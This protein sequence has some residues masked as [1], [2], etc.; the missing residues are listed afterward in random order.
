MNVYISLMADIFHAGHVRLINEGSKLGKLTV[1]LLSDKACSELGETP[2]LSYEKRK[3]VL[4]SIRGVEK[5]IKQN[6]ASYLKILPKVK[7]DYV[8]HGDDWKNNHQKIYRSEVV[9]YLKENGGELIEIP[10]SYDVNALKLK[11]QAIKNDVSSF[12]RN[13]LIKYLIKTKKTIRLIEAHN[14]ISALIVENARVQ[15]EGI[16]IEYDGFWSSSLTDSTSKGKPDIEAVDISSRLKSIDDIFDVTYKPMVFD[17]DTGGKPEHLE[18]TVKSLERLGVSAIII[19]DKVGLK[20]NSLFGNDVKQEQDTISNFCNKIKTAKKAQKTDDF[21]VIARI[22]SL[23]L[24][25][26]MD[27]AYERAIRYTSSGADGVMIHSRNKDGKEIIDFIK[28]FRKNNKDSILVV[29]PTSYNK[30][31]FE[32]FRDLNVNIVIYANHMLRSAYPN[33]KKV[34]NDILKNGRTFESEKDCMPIKDILNLIPGT[35]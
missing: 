8:L 22:E 30:I 15:I 23:I 25:K 33:M 14:P 21:L 11:E 27:D 9:K 20:K 19:E 29:V 5:I 17:G 1:G 26:G 31:K 24:D 10:Y 6:N 13:Q 3:E 32:E 12:T 35:K 28:K 4:S 18:F 34:A 2:L 16:D 7:P